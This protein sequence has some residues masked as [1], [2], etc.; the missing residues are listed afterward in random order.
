MDMAEH[1]LKT[2]HSTVSDYSTSTRERRADSGT[3]ACQ[4]TAEVEQRTLA[5]AAR[6]ERMSGASVVAEEKT[7]GTGKGKGKASPNKKQKVDAKVLDEGED[8]DDFLD[9]SLLTNVQ[10][11]HYQIYGVYWLGREDLMTNGEDPADGSFE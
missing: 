11:K 2:T 7:K 10:L 9:L 1:Y 8:V 4:S 3:V 6:M 5:Y